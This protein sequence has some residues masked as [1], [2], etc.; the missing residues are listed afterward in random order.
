MLDELHPV[1][2]PELSRVTAPQ[3]LSEGPHPP[4]CGGH[5]AP[6]LGVYIKGEKKERGER[7]VEKTKVM[8]RRMVRGAQG[9][10]AEGV[11][12]GRCPQEPWGGGSGRKRG[13]ADGPPP[14][15]TSQLS[16]AGPLGSSQVTSW[17]PCSKGR[18][19][20][21][22]WRRRRGKPWSNLVGVQ[23]GVG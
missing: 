5:T 3:T 14:A 13:P 1:E 20:S 22:V 17:G 8:G 23:P 21:A 10:Q 16:H 7:E 11:I 15:L 18:A 12:R 6:A 9:K 19:A 4:G 2:G